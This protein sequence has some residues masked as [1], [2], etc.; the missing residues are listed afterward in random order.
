MTPASRMLRLLVVLFAMAPMTD[1]ARAEDTIK[2]GLLLPFSGP[3]ADYGV[4]IGHGVDLYMKQHGDTV[5]GKRIEIIRRDTTGVAPDLAKRLA[6]E[7][8]TRDKVDFLAGFG[9]TPN[10]LAVGPIG[11]EAKKPMV[12][13]NAATS[14]ITEKSPYFVRFSF[15][16]S[17]IVSPLGAWAAKNGIKRVYVAVADYAPGL[18]AEAAFAK[19]FTAAGGEVV[20]T[21]RIPINNL[22]FA[23]YVQ[24]IKDAAP[25]GVFLFVPSGE[26]PIAFMKSYIDL[27]LRDAGVTLL[28]GTEI[29]DETVIDMLGEK[30]LGAISAQ[31]YSYAHPSPENR[32][33]LAAWQAAFGPRPRPN[34]MSVAGYDGMA[35]I[36]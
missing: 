8:V 23:A 14:V 34:F 26:Q 36:Y 27:G 20:G 24:R 21:V 32:R 6:R 1:A 29:I 10:T 33:Y 18:E 25:Q 4:Q 16:L 15:T 12:I 5:A 31:N 11:T 13:M 22:E 35:A 17:Q 19:A 28:G 7:L 30:T 9:L 3:F 2:I